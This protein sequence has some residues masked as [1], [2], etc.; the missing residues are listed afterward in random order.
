MADRIHNVLSSLFSGGY[1]QV[2]SP[3]APDRT[4]RSSKGFGFGVPWPWEE[5]PLGAIQGASGP[6]DIAVGAPRTDGRTPLFTV[7]ERGP[8]NGLDDIETQQMLR[9]FASQHS[10]RPK[11]VRKVALGGVPAQ[12]LEAWTHDGEVQLLLT[13]FGPNLLEGFLRVPMSGYLH[14]FDVF[15][16]TWTWNR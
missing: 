13:S 9:A 3:L 8:W 15:L 2:S 4:V 7:T 5:V 6:P 10:A 14:H 1:R 16:A 11:G 12:I